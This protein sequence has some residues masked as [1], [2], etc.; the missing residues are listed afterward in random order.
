[1]TVNSRVYFKERGNLKVLISFGNKTLYLWQRISPEGKHMWSARFEGNSHMT[2]GK[3]CDSHRTD[4]AGPYFFHEVILEVYLW[5]TNI[6]QHHPPGLARH[7][8]FIPHFNNLVV[9]VWICVC[10]CVCVCGSEWCYQTS[11]LG[12]RLICIFVLFIW[13]C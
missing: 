3:Y 1:M 13:W 2:T 6:G 12:C 11:L 9:F 5:K 8:I 7:L 4:G 10:V